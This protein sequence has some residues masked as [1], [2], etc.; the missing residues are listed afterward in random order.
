MHLPNK[1]FAT[2]TLVG[3]C[4]QVITEL[5]IGGILVLV[6]IGVLLALTVAAGLIEIGMHYRLAFFVQRA[7]HIS[8]EYQSLRGG[9]KGRR[10]MHDPIQIRSANSI[11]EASDDESDDEP[12]PELEIADQPWYIRL[13]LCWAPYHNFQRL[14]SIPPGHEGLKPLNA[15][16]VFSILMVIFGTTHG[17][18]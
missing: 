17:C 11:N 7:N 6:F 9:N 2:G 10:S 12:L 18:S 14:L 5:P 16:R 1:Q 4:R 3:D 13:I 8:I 15:M